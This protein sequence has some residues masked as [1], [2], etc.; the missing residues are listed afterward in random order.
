MADITGVIAQIGD[1]TDY[2]GK[3]YKKVMLGTGQELKVKQGRDG[4]LKAKWGLLKEGVAMTFKM[5][6]F[7]KP[8]GDK[9]PFVSDIV[10]VADELQPPQES[11]ILPKDQKI[12]EEARKE[13][14]KEEPAPQEL[15]MWWKEVGNRIG[16]GTIK[17][18]GVTAVYWKAYWLQM[19][20]VLGVKP[21][22]E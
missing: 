20:N 2:N 13:A 21:E 8:D 15:G 12:I 1:D 17:S 22:K 14:V 19:S 7:T 4:V 10:P 16:D 18:T 5:Q 11:T 6:D 9:I 3:A